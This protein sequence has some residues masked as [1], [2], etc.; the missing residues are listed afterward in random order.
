M[1]AS[2][3]GVAQ[4]T[5]HARAHVLSCLCWRRPVTVHSSYVHTQV[6]LITRAH[7]R[8]TRACIPAHARDAL[9]IRLLILK[10]RLTFPPA[11]HR[12]PTS[13]EQSFQQAVISRGLGDPQLVLRRG[14]EPPPPG[15]VV[16]VVVYI[17]TA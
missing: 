6:R 8:T 9:A 12:L 2:R 7:H 16:V 4:R 15:C 10:E 1:S 3:V 14:L 5:G 13:Q 17:T 11:S